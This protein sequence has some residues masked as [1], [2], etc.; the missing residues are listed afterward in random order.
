MPC[1]VFCNPTE[2]NC[3]TLTLHGSLQATDEEL[4]R[5]H[6]KDHIAEVR[7]MK[8]PPRSF[9]TSPRTWLL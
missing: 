7:I 8:P 3:A 5:T 4:Q 1:P 2:N 9:L 6:T